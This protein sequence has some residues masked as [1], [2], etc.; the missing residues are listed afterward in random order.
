[1]YYELCTGENINIRWSP[2]GKT[3]AVGNKED[4]V[5]FIDT[6]TGL[7]FIEKQF[8]YEVNEISWN[9]NGNLFFITNGQGSIPVF[10]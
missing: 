2:D 1:M 3:I 8:P 5:T 4:L 9:N 7:K 6:H 10:L